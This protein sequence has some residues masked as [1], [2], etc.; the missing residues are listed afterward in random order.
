MT[1]AQKAPAPSETERAGEVAKGLKDPEI[2]YIIGFSSGRSGMCNRSYRKS[3]VR[4]GIIAY[5]RRAG[6]DGEWRWW[7]FTPFGRLVARSLAGEG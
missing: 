7:H 1:D 5:Q 3:L 4:K 6:P 2:R